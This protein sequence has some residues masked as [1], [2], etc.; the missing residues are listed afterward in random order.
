M[1]ITVIGEGKHGMNVAR[2]YAAFTDGKTRESD[3]GDTEC[4]IEL[5]LEQAIGIIKGLADQINMA[6]ESVLQL[7]V[8]VVII[9]N[10][11]DRRDMQKEHNRMTKKSQKST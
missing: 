10:L 1:K 11:G 4:D 6:S 8:G 9:S 2:S 5:S 7:A 3:L